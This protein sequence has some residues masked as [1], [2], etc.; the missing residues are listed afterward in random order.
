MY[1]VQ[2]YT[3]CDGWVNSWKTFDDLEGE[4]E[5]VFD[6]VEEAQKELDEFFNDIHTDILNGNRACDEGYYRDEFMI[7]EIKELIAVAVAVAA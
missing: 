7:V 2:H 6:S 5:Q 3:L 4:K 1:A